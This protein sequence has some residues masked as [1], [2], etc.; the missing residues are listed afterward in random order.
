[1]LCY[2]LV[3]RCG[4]DEVMQDVLGL[5]VSQFNGIMG[6]GGESAADKVLAEQAARDHLI[7]VVERLRSTHPTEV[8]SP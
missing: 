8:K 7:K 2:Y 4:H 6:D 3:A 5:K 1:V